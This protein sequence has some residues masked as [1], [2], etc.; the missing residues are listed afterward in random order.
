[1]R[2]NSFC[3]LRLLDSLFS[4]TVVSLLLASLL[5]TLNVVEV[6][7][8][9]FLLRQWCCRL[10]STLTCLHWYWRIILLVL[11][12]VVALLAVV[13]VALFG[14]LVSDHVLADSVCLASRN[15]LFSSSWSYLITFRLIIAAEA[16]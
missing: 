3:T 9:D 7:A 8:A 1:M 16:F 4:L 10:V 12:I 2:L 5:F 14:L 15:G 13:R 6:E 11:F